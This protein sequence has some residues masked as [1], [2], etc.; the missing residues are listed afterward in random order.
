ME[1]FK[2]YKLCIKCTRLLPRGKSPG[3]SSVTKSV[4]KSVLISEGL[5]WSVLYNIYYKLYETELQQKRNYLITDRRQ[6]KRTDKQEV[7]MTKVDNVMKRL[8]I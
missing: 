2:M 8:M 5:Y 3:Y 1:K 4:N 7:Q 6:T